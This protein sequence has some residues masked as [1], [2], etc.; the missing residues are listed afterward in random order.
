MEL[1]L[2]G[3]LSASDKAYI[4]GFN[5]GHSINEIVEELYEEGF[6]SEI[7]ILG[8]MDAVSYLVTK[9][10]VYVIQDG[11]SMRLRAVD[12]QHLNGVIEG[13]KQV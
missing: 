7:R 4:L 12:V 10:D 1:V 3:V 2:K 6:T 5:N 9:Y 11:A 13:L 8:Y